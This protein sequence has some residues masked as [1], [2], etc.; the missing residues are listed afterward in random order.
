[1]TFSILGFDKNK[2]EFG[3]AICSAVPCI[4]EFFVFGDGSAGII[5]AQG[6]FNPYNGLKGIE[7]LKQ[8]FS[9]NEILI[10]L[11]EQDSYIQKR[12]IAIL[13]R[14]GKMSCFTGE[15]LGNGQKL[16]IISDEIIVCGNTLA[17]I[18]TVEL[19]KKSFENNKEESLYLKLLAALK[20]GN[21]SLG[22]LR[23]R[24]SAALHIYSTDNDYP[25]IKF[26]IDDDEDPVITLEKKVSK[27]MKS[28]YKLMP[29][30]PQRNGNQLIPEKGSIGEK[31][32][33]E[34][35][36]NVLLRNFD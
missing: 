15:S 18:D 17:D 29:Y 7:M 19:M 25:I 34:F 12:Q 16:H 24:Q 20:L 22:D 1:M 8:N 35:K 30:F 5:A 3:I 6:S 32:F 14:N 36:K 21:S 13:S 27:Y 28:F 26:N 4:G 11:K 23:G 33:S 10:K 31:T 9:P 2:N